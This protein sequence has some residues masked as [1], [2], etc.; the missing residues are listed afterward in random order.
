VLTPS[1]QPVRVT[2]CGSLT[3]MTV[4]ARWPIWPPSTCTR[5]ECSAAAN[6][7][8][9]IEPFTRLVD[10]VMTAEP[11][12]SAK[13]VFFI[14]DNASSHRGTSA[15][16]RLTA[17][18]PNAVMIHAPVHASWLKQVE[19]YFSIVQ[20]KVLT[21]NNFA[22]LAAVEQRLTAF[23]DCYNRTAKSFRWRYTTA[24]L[25]EHLIRLDRCHN[26]TAHAA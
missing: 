3:T 15:I 13:R 2:Q 19:I 12:A 10:Q 5:L 8:P 1:H 21:P 24:D 22:D 17:R 26:P 18:Y 11:Y 20:R 6:P 9:A 4:A 25:H 7:P 23:Q 16:D 14:V